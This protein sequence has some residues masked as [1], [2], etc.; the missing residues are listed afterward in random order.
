MNVQ[1]RTW[2][3]YTVTEGCRTNVVC[4]GGRGNWEGSKLVASEPRLE[5]V[6]LWA[7]DN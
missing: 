5:D 6:L 3:T 2:L 1:T 4:V 7:E